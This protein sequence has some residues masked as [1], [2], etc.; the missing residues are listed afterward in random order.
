MIRLFYLVLLTVLV[1]ITAIAGDVSF[2]HVYAYAT[3][4]VQ[5]NGAVFMVITNHSDHDDRILSASASVS[6]R[7]ELHTHM[8]DGGIMMMRQVD[9]Y[10]VPSGETVTLEP[11]GHHVMLMGLHEPLKAGEHFPLTLHFEQRD[12]LVVDV[13]IKNP[14]DIE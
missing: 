1:P 4:P 3:A 5:K 12:P 7:V 8:M 6:E 13:A 14:G 11:M 10:D 9:A 2:S